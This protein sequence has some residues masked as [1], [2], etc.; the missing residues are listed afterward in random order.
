MDVHT[1]NTAKNRPASLPIWERGAY[2]LAV[3]TGILM[4]GSAQ[5]QESLQM[6][7][8]FLGQDSF[9]ARILG[10]SLR[11]D[12]HLA[13][14]F[15]LMMGLVIFSTTAA[16]MYI[17]ERKAWTLRE[18]MLL[19]Q[20]EDLRR[21]DDRA[22]LLLN[23]ERQVVI[24]WRC[25][26]E[27]PWI[28][29]D[30]SILGV[31]GISSPRILGF[32][33]WLKAPQAAAIEHAIETLKLRGES[34][35]LV[36]E[37]LSHRII[38]A[39]GRA[40]G[41]AALVRLRD[42]TG[43]RAALIRASSELDSLRSQSAGLSA[44]FEALSIP[45]WL[46]DQDNVL[47]YANR[48]FLD[49]VE[50]KDLPDARQRSLELLERQES[51]SFAKARHEHVP[52][53]MRTAT[54]IGGLRKILDVSETPL[55]KG[56]A[57]FAVDA[58][59]LEAVRTDLHRQM[60]AHVRTLDQLPTAVA[61]FDARQTLVFHNTAYR[62]LWALE[63]H[64][65]ET[66]PSDG[67]IL[68]RL[69]GARKL[70]EQADF[71]VWKATLLGSYRAVE[72]QEFWWHLPDRRTLRVIANPNPQ[73]GVTYLFDDVSERVHLQSQYNALIKAQGE[74]LDTLKEGVVVFGTDGRLKLCNPSFREMWRLN[75]AQAKEHPHIDTIITRCQALMP[76]ETL[77]SEIRGAVAGLSEARVNLSFRMERKDGMVLDCTSQP[78]PDG[79]TLLT[80][81]D[82]T[83]SV[84]VERALTE[85]NE[86]L[87]NTARLRDEFVHHVSYQLRSP[88]TN[89]IGFTQL[90][91][92]ESIGPLNTR[93]REYTGHILSSSG[94]LLAI[95]NDILDL[96]TIDNG[97]M[98][99]KLEEVD[100][101]ATIQAAAR[102]LED[103]F[104]EAKV[105]FHIEAPTGI[106]HFTADGQ[107]LRQI[108][109]NLLSNAIGFSSPGQAVTLAV[110]RDAQ[111][112][113]FEVKD[114]G[115]GIP[116]E[117]RDSIFGRF[118]SH[119]RGTRHR[120]AGLGLSIV[121][122]FVELHGGGIDLH[123]AP[124]AGTLVRV[125]FPYKSADQQQDA[126]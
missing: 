100:I 3:F 21:A 83:A 58:S 122:A 45:L 78:L 17:R 94:S 12:A 57:G 34:F 93:Q 123:S 52:L 71:R 8:R 72:A 6:Q 7:E 5:A 99:L 50:A 41:G 74:T 121:R 56:M 108:L 67:E 29:G 114:E 65:L 15:S 117:L 48:A 95:I 40:V 35:D 96:A 82:M 75:E 19:I 86:A 91:G 39:Q 124:G 88:L 63:Q 70:P 61:I 89:I 38:E 23:A 106:G 60:E 109:F 42:L 37:T 113:V 62:D 98:E 44:L 24:A 112:V 10:A 102:G 116:E 14:G 79:S 104:T 2:F 85:K 53:R 80:F 84:N 30:A 46:R 90:L 11:P 20:V 101:L 26:S 111:D 33:A 27:D 66:K 105:T 49:A 76:D 118:E 32:G 51:E 77:W 18:R 13:F 25:R 4:F 115:A 47:T 125:S 103:R 73:G 69:R 126:A 64:Y 36:L 68:E 119:T 81:V 9:I 92:D 120:G 55:E 31:A 1:T 28:E 97:A 16:L 107:R 59:E 54:V 110:R 22:N 87:E 43:D